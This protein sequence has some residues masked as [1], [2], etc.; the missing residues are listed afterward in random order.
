MIGINGDGSR[1]TLDVAVG[2]LIALRGYSEQ[3]AFAELLGVVNR[4]G[5]GVFAV[6]NS[7]VAVATG[8]STAADSEAFSAWGDL[9]RRARGTRLAAAS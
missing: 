5:Q 9:L 4:T 8:A 7:L 3:D 6:A 1:R 2:I